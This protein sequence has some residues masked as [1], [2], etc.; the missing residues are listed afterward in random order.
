MPEDERTLAE[1]EQGTAGEEDPTLAD[2]ENGTGTG[3]ESTSAEGEGAED[4]EGGEGEKPPSLDERLAEEEKNRQQKGPD[5]AGFADEQIR[6]IEAGTLD[7]MEPN[8]AR[9][10]S[11]ALQKYGPAMAA[12][13]RSAGDR[14]QTQTGRQTGDPFQGA[15]VNARARQQ[16]L[17]DEW[18]EDVQH[19]L[20]ELKAYADNPPTDEEWE[21]IRPDNR[22][23]FPLTPA[24]HRAWN[25]A[26]EKLLRQ[27]ETQAGQGSA[28]DRD[29]ARAQKV[30]RRS[31]VQGQQPVGAGTRFETELQDVIEGKMSPEDYADRQL[32]RMTNPW[33]PNIP[34]GA[35]K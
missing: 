11:A 20:G 27:K 35:K 23:K 6:L 16:E 2:V 32:Q 18:N 7:D 8:T 26:A 22:Q 34:A 10:V 13:D 25:R 12:R 31:Q 17:A 5:M 19:V 21:S 14:R 3:A 28:V 1:I 30:D 24:G 9:I 29:R 4:K 15:Q 33:A